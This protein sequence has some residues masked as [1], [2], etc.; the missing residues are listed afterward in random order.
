[1]PKTIIIFLINTMLIN[2]AFAFVYSA[3]QGKDVIPENL[4]S[5]AINDW[6]NGKLNSFDKVSIDIPKPSDIENISSEKLEMIY[7]SYFKEV[8]SLRKSLEEQID[9]YVKSHPFKK[10]V[11]EWEKKAN[12]DNS[13]LLDPYLDNLG[14]LKEKYFSKLKII[15]PNEENLSEKGKANDHKNIRWEMLI[16]IG[17][18]VVCLAVIVLLNNNLRAIFRG[19]ARSMRNSQFISNLPLILTISIV[20]VGGLI[21]GMFRYAIFI[22]LILSTLSIILNER[23]EKR[24]RKRKRN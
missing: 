12:Q 18:F 11:I 1:M 24:G 14:K 20:S 5:A 3:P 22:N 2:F 17:V 10:S 23:F 6:K 21:T 15:S 9:N 7:S 16:L 13:S 8:D 19:D 4:G